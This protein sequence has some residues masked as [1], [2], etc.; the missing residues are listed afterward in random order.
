MYKRIILL[1]L[2]SLVFFGAGCS[3]LPGSKGDDKAVEPKTDSVPLSVDDGSKLSSGIELV[4]PAEGAVLTSPI[5][6]S[7]QAEVLGDKVYVRVKNAGGKTVIEDFTMAKGGVF[8]VNLDFQFR[9]TTEG[10]VEVFGKDGA[11]AEVGLQSVAV[12][13]EPNL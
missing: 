3:I 6:V 5:L 1:S 13:F 12:K 4:N 2:A 10:T 11:G 9:G 8:A 7:G